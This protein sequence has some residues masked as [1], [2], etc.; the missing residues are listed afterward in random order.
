[1]PAV[2]HTRKYKVTK[3]V[4]GTTFNPDGTTHKSWTVHVEHEDGTPGTV[5]LPD[6]YYTAPNVHNAVADQAQHVHE[7]ADLPDS[8]PAAQARLAAEA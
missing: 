6:A 4:P 8:L 7:V 2:K 1:M 5:E 3:Q